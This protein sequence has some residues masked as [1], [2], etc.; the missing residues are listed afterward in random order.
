MRG[1]VKKSWGAWG[2]SFLIVAAA[3]APAQADWQGTMRMYGKGTEGAKGKIF[4]KGKKMRMDINLRG[5]ETTMLMDNTAAGA[6]GPKAM[7]LMHKQKLIMETQGDP[8]QAQSVMCDPKDADAC[9]S[10]NGFKKVRSEMMLGHMCDVYEGSRDKGGKKGIQRLWR[11][12]NLKEVFMVKI[13]GVQEGQ[14][15]AGMEFHDIK[16]AAIAD[17][18]FA[19]PAGYNRMPDLSAMMKG[20]GGKMPPGGMPPGAMPP[21]GR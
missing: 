13:E 17:S 9:L 20:M 11:P 16:V 1:R 19:V 10:K 14:P 21:S 3:A 6:K 8:V 15:P 18:V 5:Q 4:Y 12:K 7:M 2:I